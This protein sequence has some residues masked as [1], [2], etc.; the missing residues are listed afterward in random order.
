MKVRVTI[1]VSD[2]DRRYLRT[3]IGK[4]GLATRAEVVEAVTDFFKSDLNAREIEEDDGKYH[5]CP[6]EKP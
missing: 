5:N 2:C 3:R 4:P 6:S 1:E